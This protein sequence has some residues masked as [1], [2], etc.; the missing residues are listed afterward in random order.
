MLD[1]KYLYYEL[2]FF[3]NI[4]YM[5]NKT[6][7]ISDDISLNSSL[8]DASSNSSS[9]NSSNSSSNNS[10]N[11]NNSDFDFESESFFSRHKYKIIISA[12]ILILLIVYLIYYLR[13]KSHVR[14]YKDNKLFYN[15][16]QIL[17]GSEKLKESDENIK[18]TLS[19]FIRLNNL[20][21][22]TVWSENQSFKKYIINNRGSP[23][24]V[25][26]RET[27]HVIVEIAYKSKDGV[28]DLYEFRFENFPLQ[29]WTQI[30]VVVNRRIISIYKDGELYTAKKLDTIPWK[31]QGIFFIGQKN[32]NFNGYI[33]LIDYYNRSLEADEVKKLYRKRVNKLP[34]SVLTYEEAEYYKN[35]KTILGKIDKINKV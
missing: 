20:D 22:N 13:D 5:T 7:N 32:K 15:N 18:Y 3:I 35:K 26:E 1:V 31:S 27:G 6:K 16:E 23:N 14:I 21:G 17:V 8:S 24:I 4:F 34:D 12:I 9:N 33:G 28:N 29:K 19:T 2:K 30:C 10:S 25:F 11:N